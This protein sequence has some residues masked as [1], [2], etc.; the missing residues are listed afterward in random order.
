MAIHSAKRLRCERFERKPKEVIVAPN[1]QDFTRSVAGNEQLETDLIEI[2][3]CIEKGTPLNRRFY[4]S[5][6][7]RDGD[8]LLVIW[9]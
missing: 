9:N 8:P 6:I 1:Y 3:D 7:A 4:R 5:G 2:V